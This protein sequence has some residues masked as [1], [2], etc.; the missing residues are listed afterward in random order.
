MKGQ[1]DLFREQNLEQ[2]RAIKVRL[3]PLIQLEAECCECNQ[4]DAISVPT[5]EFYRFKD[6]ELVQN[7]WPKMSAAH[8]EIILGAIN[9]VYVCD[10]C[11]SMFDE[12][13]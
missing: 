1:Q 10:R 7:V 13:G 2:V 12:R 5:D 3:S 6:G 9:R 11:W 4:R 8:R